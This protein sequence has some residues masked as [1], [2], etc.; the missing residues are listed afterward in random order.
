MWECFGRRRRNWMVAAFFV[1]A[2]TY[3]YCMNGDLL[4]HLFWNGYFATDELYVDHIVD[5]SGGALRYWAQFTNQ[6]LLSPLLGALLMAFLSTL[7]ACCSA[8]LFQLRGYF[9]SLSFLPS[10]FLLSMLGGM[11]Y[12]ICQMPDTSLIICC[13][14]GVLVTLSLLA[15]YLSSGGLRWGVPIILVVTILLYPAIGGYSLLALLLMTVAAW[16]S[17]R[18]AVNITIVTIVSIV[19]LPYL[20]DVLWFGDSYG[21]GIRNVMFPVSMY[22][23]L[24]IQLLVVLTLTL[25]GWVATK[26]IRFK[27]VTESTVQ[28]SVLIGMFLAVF[29]MNNRNAN[30]RAELKLPRLADSQRWE[31]ML[32]C[33]KKVETPTRTVNAYRVIALMYTDQLADRLFKVKYPFAKSELDYEARLFEEDLFFHVGFYNSSYRVSMETWQNFG[34]NYRR[35]KNLFFCSLMN[36]E[37]ELAERYLRQLSQSPVLNAFVKRGNLYLSDSQTLF[38]DY[39][40]WRKIISLAPQEDVLFLGGAS[41]SR[42]YMCYNYLQPAC[43]E[44]RILSDLWERNLKVF[45]YDLPASLPTFSHVPDCVKEAAVIAVALHGANPSLLQLAQVDEATQQKV[46]SFFTELRSN[47]TNAQERLR[48]RYGKTYS[49]YYACGTPFDNIK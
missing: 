42:Y 17:K 20:F 10:A 18:N 15:L 2:W 11:G 3:L 6:A 1:Y 37:K 41:L 27:K 24:S 26:D 14:W 34:L 31:E 49:Y 36:G 40:S 44:N 4:Y 33:C 12:A 16:R 45:T 43:Y 19:L 28:W 46:I 23:L 38:E 21:S 32:A 29:G 35:L 30:Y 5:H 7:I 8:F 25:L 48:A 13:F 39:P 47:P 9:Y 22:H